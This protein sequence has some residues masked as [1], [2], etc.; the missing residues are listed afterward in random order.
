MYALSFWSNAL[1]TQRWRWSG[2]PIT[3]KLTKSWS[4]LNHTTLSG[5]WPPT[6]SFSNSKQSL[7]VQSCKRPLQAIS[8]LWQ[9]L[10]SSSLNSRQSKNKLN[11]RQ[12]KKKSLKRQTT[13]AG[14]SSQSW[15][16]CWKIMREKALLRSKSMHFFLTL[17]KRIR[18]SGKGCLLS[19]WNRLRLCSTA[20][21]GR[22]RLTRRRRWKCIT[23]S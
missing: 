17:L 6:S 13:N 10:S 22:S 14:V 4:A 21:I 16:I 15:I 2:P 1:R 20:L 9:P 5:R 7:N 11:L 8:K 12:V 19:T 3:A 23:T 18:R